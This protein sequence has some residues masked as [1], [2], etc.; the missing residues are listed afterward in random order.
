MDFF[1]LFLYIFVAIYIAWIWVDYY[2][3]I[4]IYESERLFHFIFMFTLG[5][6]SVFLTLEVNAWLDKY[7]HTELNGNFLHD[8]LICFLYIG[9]VE[10]LSKLLPFLI[11]IL[12]FPK[13]LNESIDYIA[14]ICA[15]ALGF[16]AVENVLYFYNYGPHIIS[17]RAILSSL[18]HMFDTALIAYG[19]ILF[20]FRYHHKRWYLIP[21]FIFLAAFAHGVYD[22][23]LMYQPINRIGIFLAI[24]YFLVTISLF[25]TIINNA[26]NQSHFF[27]YK[28]VIDSQKVARRLLMYYAMIFLI[29]LIILSYFTNFENALNNLWSTLLITGMVIVISCIRLSRFKLIKGRWFPLKIEMPFA[30]VR[31]V[32]EDR[33]GEIFRIVVKGESFN[34]VYINRF[35]ESFFYLH[36][37]Q[38]IY[39]PQLAYL[40]RKVF[41]VN[42]VTCYLVRRYFSDQYNGFEYVLLYPKKTGK[43]RTKENYPYVEILKFK[44]MELI[45]KGAITLEQL[46]FESW[47]ILSP[48]K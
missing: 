21:F 15:A 17:S 20:K 3:L 46:T 32:K 16:S 13:I 12:V 37:V 30:I 22:F 10:E 36:P 26:L 25:A 11:F 43:T 48:K 41:L 45:E 39:P 47:G 8:F 4:D 18:G 33:E 14:F 38:S 23:L 6:A 1:E 35:Y 42:D 40:E 29:Q 34:E 2:R 31:K 28:K 19:I 44:R 24:A 27:T 7:F 9:L 5:C